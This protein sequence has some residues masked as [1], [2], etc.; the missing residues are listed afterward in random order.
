MSGSIHIANMANKYQVELEI[1]VK[2][3]KFTLQSLGFKMTL[4]RDKK[5]FKFW[6]SLQLFFHL[7]K[8]RVFSEDRSRFYAAEIILAVKYLHE[9]KVVYRDLKVWYIVLHILGLLSFCCTDFW[10]NFKSVTFFF[11][12]Q[13]ENL[14]LDSDG[15]IKLTD[16]GLCKEDITYG[17]TT[18]TFC[19]TPEYLAPEV[20]LSVVGM[21][22]KILEKVGKF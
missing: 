20:S 11:F 9:H 4:Y 22:G 12:S 19:G 10:H 18:K 2:P 17:S 7:S 15:H 5:L 21:N 1:N 16:F 8:E 13:L 6:F 14:L 3:N